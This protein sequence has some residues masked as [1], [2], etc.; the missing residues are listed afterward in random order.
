MTPTGGHLRSLPK[1]LVQVMKLIE[2]A[3][4]TSKNLNN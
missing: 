3:L 1:M 2:F 4:Y